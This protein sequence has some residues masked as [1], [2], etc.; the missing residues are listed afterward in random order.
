MVIN[1][2][3]LPLRGVGDSSLVR[4]MTEGV[5]FINITTLVEQ[6]ELWL[7]QR[8][9]LSLCKANGKAWWSSLPPKVQ[10]NSE[11]RHRW[12]TAQIGVRRA[13]PSQDIA[14]LSMGD[15]ISVLASLS[16]NDWQSCL[17]AETYRKKE[18]ERALYKVK[19]FRD[20]Y[21][22]H[23][24]PREISKFEM[25]TLARTVQ[26]FPTIL[27]PD[28]WNQAMNLLGKIKTLSPDGRM[29]LLSI[30]MSFNKHKSETLSKQV[31]CPD[32]DEPP[33]CNHDRKLNRRTTNWRVHVIRIC[34][35]Y[36]SGGYV[37]FGRQD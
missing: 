3:Y 9:E 11:N 35:D 31:E 15:V 26:R 25:A 27:K 7:K 4:G 10:R 23:P 13:G 2:R 32:L 16:K 17:Q 36:D 29:Q 12:A 33:Y 6:I 5:L 18:F 14:W 1:D 20:N 28:E 24:K 22:A 8:I 34:A 19:A 21:L 30:A 37:F